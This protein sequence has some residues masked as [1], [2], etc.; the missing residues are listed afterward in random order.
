MVLEV[1]RIERISD[2][3]TGV[4]AVTAGHVYARR[5]RVAELRIFR[6]KPSASSCGLAAILKFGQ[7]AHERFILSSSLTS[8]PVGALACTVR[9]TKLARTYGSGIGAVRLIAM[10]LMASSF[11]ALAQ[12]DSLALVSGTV[13]LYLNLTSPSGSEPATVQWTLTYPAG[14]V[15][16][17]SASP[18]TAATNASKT[19][20]CHAASGAYS[21]LV[22]GMNSNAISNGTVALVSISLA[23]GVSSAA[24][25]ISNVAAGSGAGEGISISGT[26]STLTAPILVSIA[27]TPANASLAKGLTQQFTATGTYSNGSTQNLSASA[28]WSSTST[29]VASIAAGGV[30]TGVAAGSATIKATS[31]GISG[32]TALTVTAATLKSIAITPANASIAKG[33]TQQFTATGTYSDSSTQN[34]TTSAAWSSSSASVATIAAGGL[35]TGVAAGS[36]TIQATSGGIGGSTGLTVTAATLVSTLICTPSS[37]GANASSACT[38]TLTAPLPVERWSL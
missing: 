12:L 26:G 18:G 7:L 34:L 2:G 38:V 31:G 6:L 37:L 15:A 33:S 17:I 35:A 9:R 20:S 4:D 30:A 36:T 21:C 13:P 8:S 23:A 24:I 10:A 5:G 3:L 32:S 29:G 11:P 16:S 14:A 25:A 27:V 1:K 28:T 22:W 19:L